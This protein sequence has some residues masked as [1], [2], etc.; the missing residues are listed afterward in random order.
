MQSA[1]VYFETKT[2]PNEKK[3]KKNVEGYQWARGGKNRADYKVT[4]KMAFEKLIFF[5]PKPGRKEREEATWT[6]IKTLLSHA[7]TLFTAQI[8]PVHLQFAF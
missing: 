7:F 3:H 1:F 2:T 6:G 4:I 5:L 8:T